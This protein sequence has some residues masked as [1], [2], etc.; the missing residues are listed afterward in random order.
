MKK[1]ILTINILL[2][3]VTS[4]FS[5]QQVLTYGEAVNIAVKQNITIKQQKNQLKVNQAEKRQSIANFLPGVGASGS[6]Y[7][8]DGLQFSNEVSSLVN[9]SIDRVNYNIGANMTIFNGL[10]NVYRLKQTNQLY[11]AQKEQVEQSVHDIILQVSQQFLQVIL[12]KELLI[13][14]KEDS[15]VQKKLYEQLVAYVKVG[16][17]TETELLTQEAQLKTSEATL[18]TK[19]NKLRSDK[20]ELAKT[21]LFKPGKEFNVIGP[22]WDVDSI[23]KIRYNPDSLMQIAIDNRPDLKRLQAKRNASL[24]GVRVSQSGYMPSISIYYNYGSYFASNNLRLNPVDSMYHQITFKNQLLKENYSSQ[25]GFNISIPIFNRMQTRTN[26]VQSKIRYENSKLAY[27]DFEMQLFLDVQKACQDFL[28]DKKSYLAK[29][30]SADAFQ[31]AYQKQLEMYQVGQG[32]LVELNIENQRNIQAQSEK[33]QAEY[34]L[35]FQQIVLQY[36]T[37]RLRN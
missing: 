28:S 25:Y 29:V 7:R 16:T 5:Q 34:T 9:T 6:A 31:K 14:A 35:Y 32:S 19:Q 36:Y 4:L 3:A 1:S 10:V 12:D 26:V 22:K 13:I 24:Q 33:I 8:T 18:I 20:A 21:L 2:L 17:R 11:E 15:V 23:L 37:G 30:T 27:K